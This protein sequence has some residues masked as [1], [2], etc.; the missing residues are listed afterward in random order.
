MH[1]QRNIKLLTHN[2]RTVM[3]QL[4]RMVLNFIN[5]SFN[6]ALDLHILKQ[7]F[8]SLKNFGK[9]F[10]WRYYFNK[11]SIVSFTF[12]SFTFDKISTRGTK[13]ELGFRFSEEDHDYK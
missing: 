4:E 9:V 12:E 13:F 10:A 5:L 11:N 1:Y 6:Y 2:K 8:E 3:T 7:S